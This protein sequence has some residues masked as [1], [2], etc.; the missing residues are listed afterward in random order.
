MKVITRGT[1]PTFRAKY[2]TI[3]TNTM[4]HAYLT[5]SQGSLTIEKSLKE[6]TKS[7][8]ELAWR[9]TQEDTLAL[10]EGCPAT[11]QVRYVLSNGDAGASRIYS[12]S[13]LPLVK[14]G[15]I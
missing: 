7:A 11:Y 8:N 15:E 2:R 9:L 10:R 1:T 4:T 5:I 13:V 6:A 14:D 3:P 12:F